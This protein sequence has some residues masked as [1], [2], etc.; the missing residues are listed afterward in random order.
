[1]LIGILLAV[2]SA[3]S[4]NSGFVMEK[5]ALHQLPEIHARRSAHM[6]VTLASSPLWLSGFALS[7]FGLACQV[8]ALS[9]APLSV[10][11]PIIAAGIAVLLLLSHFVL[12]EH[13]GRLEWIGVATV[14]VAIALIGLSLDT[15]SDGIGT[16]ASFFRVVVVSVPTLVLGALTFVAAGRRQR[17]SAPLYGLASGLMYG[18]AGVA[19][20]AVSVVVETDGVVRAIPSVLASPDLYLLLGFAAAGLLMFQ[21]GLQR[22]RAS[23]VV[24]VSNVVSAAYPIAVGMVLFG[25]HL[26][27][28]A[29]RLVLRTAGFAGV[30]VGTALLS[31]GRGLQAAYAVDDRPIEVELEAAASASG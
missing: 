18:V 28:S 20:K 29:W 27:Q 11:Q 5:R 23:V 26:P 2:V 21:T 16:G 25:E 24:P 7:L 22:G 30:L 6:L 9:K 12:R 8:L 15:R 17:V 1:M 13:L 31:T 3:V 19:T 10:V 14:G 4:F